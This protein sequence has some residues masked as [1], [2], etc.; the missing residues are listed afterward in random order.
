MESKD[1][2]VIARASKCQKVVEEHAAAAAVEKRKISGDR[3]ESSK[4]GG[5]RARLDAQKK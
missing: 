4:S 3:G 5:W 1:Y 2:T